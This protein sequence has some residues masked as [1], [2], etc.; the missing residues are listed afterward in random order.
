MDT[1]FLFLHGRWMSKS[2]AFIGEQNLQTTTVRQGILPQGKDPTSPPA[3][4]CIFW[5]PNSEHKEEI[6]QVEGGPSIQINMKSLNRTKAM[7]SYLLRTKNWFRKVGQCPSLSEKKWPHPKRERQLW[8]KHNLSLCMTR[9][10]EISLS[11]RDS[12]QKGPLL[13]MSQ[14]R[15]DS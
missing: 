12:H 10:V 15:D 11:H 4:S 14:Q 6:H 2:S 7:K 13:G 9:C 1:A 8:A 5:W 3:Q